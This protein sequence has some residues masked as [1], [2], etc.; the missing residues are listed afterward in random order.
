MAA[1]PVRSKIP[2]RADAPAPEGTVLPAAP[3]NPTGLTEPAPLDN[4]KVA[5][6]AYHLWL[7]RGC[8]EGSPD[9]DW[10][11]AEEEVRRS[12]ASGE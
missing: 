6:I 3:D 9:E 5:A 7:E 4:E 1:Q 2:K 11:R 12:A 10:Y 8:P